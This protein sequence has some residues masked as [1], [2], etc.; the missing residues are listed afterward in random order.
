MPFVF[1]VAN[2]ANVSNV[3]D[4]VKVSPLLTS[5]D[6]REFNGPWLILQTDFQDGTEALEEV[7]QRL[8]DFA[9]SYP[10]RIF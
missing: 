5:V 4:V 10:G 1:K 6:D 9:G 8:R 2:V 7:R 3:V